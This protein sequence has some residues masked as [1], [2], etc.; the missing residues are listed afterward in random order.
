MK[1]MN[2][3]KLWKFPKFMSSLLIAC[4]S[5][6]M[7]F[8]MWIQ[9]LA[10]VWRVLNLAQCF[11]KLLHAVRQQST[12]SWVKANVFGI[13]GPNR[14]SDRQRNCNGLHQIVYSKLVNFSRRSQTVLELQNWKIVNSKCNSRNSTDHEVFSPNQVCGTWVSLNETLAKN[15][16]PD[17]GIRNNASEQNRNKFRFLPNAAVLF[18]RLFEF[19]LWTRSAA[20]VRNDGH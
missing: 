8:I 4:V 15:S 13:W 6:I 20:S 16:Q 7:W 2:V 9:L 17:P 18:D 1:V 11:N 19:E 12:S 5:R 3:W 14:L 10:Q